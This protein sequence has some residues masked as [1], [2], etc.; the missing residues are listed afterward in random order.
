MCCSARWAG[1]WSGWTGRQRVLVDLEG[2]GRE[3]IFPGVDLSRTVG[4]FTT[5]F[6]VALDLHRRG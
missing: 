3:E 4:W 1:C 2:H 5:M 6:P